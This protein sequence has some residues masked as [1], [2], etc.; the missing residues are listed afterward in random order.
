MRGANVS[1]IP[2]VARIAIVALEY[3]AGSS[4]DSAVHRAAVWR[5]RQDQCDATAQ[6][7]GHQRSQ[8]RA[9]RGGHRLPWLRTLPRAPG[10]PRQALPTR[11]VLDPDGVRPRC[12]ASTSVVPMPHMG[13]STILLARVRLIARRAIS[14]SIFAG[15]A[16]ESGTYRPRRCILDGCCAH[17][18]TDKGGASS[19]AFTLW[20]HEHEH[21]LVSDQMQ[22]EPGPPGPSGLVE[23]PE[24]GP[25]NHSP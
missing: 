4:P 2:C 16:T 21:I 25:G 12:I 13:S 3:L 24:R 11:L 22:R 9:H 7:C 19:M 20:F 10:W 23:L 5:R 8:S 1:Q 18:Q 17:G 14:G 6:R 15:C